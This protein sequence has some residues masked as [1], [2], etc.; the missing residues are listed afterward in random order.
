MLYELF[1]SI[2]C[3]NSLYKSY[4][5]HTGIAQASSVLPK[6]NNGIGSQYHSRFPMTTTT[7]SIQTQ[8]SPASS[9]VLINLPGRHHPSYS[10][11]LTTAAM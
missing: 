11:N 3:S 6:H 9:E 10:S 8:H 7:T 2:D 4:S 5:K 1:R